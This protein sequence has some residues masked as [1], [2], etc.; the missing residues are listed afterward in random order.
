MSQ[1]WEVLMPW[2]QEAPTM[3]ARDGSDAIPLQGMPAQL[4]PD[5]ADTL[6]GA[7]SIGMDGANPWSGD[8]VGSLHHDLVVHGASVGMP[9]H[10]ALGGAV[11]TLGFLGITG[12]GGAGL[13]LLGFVPTY[14][15]GAGGEQH[16]AGMFACHSRG[17]VVVRDTSRSRPRYPTSNLG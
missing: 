15:L 7:I 9:K 6:L 4:E 2:V 17:K 11:P 3:H 10:T 13:L 8:D 12:L 5:A 14:Q 16:R 1:V